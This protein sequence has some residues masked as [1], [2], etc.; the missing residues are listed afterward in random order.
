MTTD[1]HPKVASWEH[2]LIFLVIVA[3]VTA[4]GLTAQGQPSA[5]GEL[6]ASHASAL[7][8]YLAASGLD[9]LLFFF[10]WR[11]IRAHG[12]RMAEI[13]GG[14]WSNPLIVLCDLALSA[15]FFGVLLAATWGLSQLA[16]ATD[17]KS[18]ENLLPQTPL[19]VGVWLFTC[20]TAGFCE[21][22]VFRGYAQRQFLALTNSSVVAVVGQAALFGVMHSYQGLKPTAEIVVLGILFGAVAAWRKTLRIGMLAH[23]SLDFWEGWLSR[24]VMH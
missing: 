2:S 17:A 14:R 23:A 8:I 13:V 24:V 6:V 16:G 20:V 21:E 10:V 19:E 1:T 9:W 11:G 3:G 22:F 12:G 18:I 7:P 5:G 4:A 15:T